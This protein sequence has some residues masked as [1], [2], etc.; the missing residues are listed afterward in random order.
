MALLITTALPTTG[1]IFKEDT[2]SQKLLQ[3]PLQEKGEII[4]LIF[5]DC[6]GKAPE[7]RDIE[8]T[9]HEW[10]NFCDE[11]RTIRT[12]K[13]TIEKYFEAQ[14]ALFKEY[15]LISNDMTFE[16]LKDRV[17]QKFKDK[18]L[19]SP[20]A[21]QNQNMIYNTMCAI[22][23][24]IENGS[25]LVFG[26]NTFVNKIGLDIFSLHFGY[27]PEGIETRG[28]SNQSLGPGD[29]IGFM[30]GFLGYWAGTQ[31]GTGRYS[32]LFVSGFTSITLWL[33]LE[34]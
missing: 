20:R 2:I 1:Y 15:N 27:A 8:F 12:E 25:N 10:N 6:T 19:R 18:N 33:K 13:N 14:I 17:D 23:F 3:K 22:K 21:P 31:T 4:N 34:S 9:E 16:I 29:F 24:D 26:L 5:W 32:D 30:F 7:K 11:L 28:D